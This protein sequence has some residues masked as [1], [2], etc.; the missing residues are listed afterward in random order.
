MIPSIFDCDKWSMILID[1]DLIK[2]ANKSTFEGITKS[3]MYYK[4]QW[5]VVLSKQNGTFSNPNFDSLLKFKSGDRL[6]LF[7]LHIDID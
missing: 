1:D 5:Y 2:Y 3:K 4:E 6:Y 7:N